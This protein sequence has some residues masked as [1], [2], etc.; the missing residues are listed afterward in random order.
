MAQPCGRG[1]KKARTLTQEIWEFAK[2]SPGEISEFDLEDTVRLAA[3]LATPAFRNSGVEVPLDEDQPGVPVMITADKS[4]MTQ[5]LV[6]LLLDAPASLPGG[7]IVTWSIESHGV[8]INVTCHARGY[9]DEVGMAWPI[10]GQATEALGLQNAT[11]EA[12]PEGGSVT[13]SIPIA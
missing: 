7:G 12:A 4:L 8:S 11:A 3:R 13:V 2:S 10:A 9:D 1:R 6:A 5:A